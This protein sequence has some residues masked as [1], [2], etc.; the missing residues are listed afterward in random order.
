MLITIL[1]GLHCCKLTSFFC[2]YG[3][4]TDD[5]GHSTNH[6]KL[7]LLFCC[8]GANI[9]FDCS[10]HWT[11]PNHKH[12]NHINLC[13]LMN[14]WTCVS[15][16]QIM[17]A[18]RQPTTTNQTTKTSL[19]VRIDRRISHFA[20]VLWHKHNNEITICSDDCQ[21]IDK[22]WCLQHIFHWTLKCNTNPAILGAFHRSED[23]PTKWG[24]AQRSDPLPNRTVDADCTSW[25]YGC[26]QMC[27][28]LASVSRSTDDA[29]K[30]FLLLCISVI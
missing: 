9:L 6:R 12:C 7:A 13:L 19:H 28:S 11:P 25:R 26:C 16:L 8:R 18:V 29:Y 1:P 17:C 2:D 22:S 3:L 14:C 27:A 30:S 20:F 5:T 15:S 10:P 21:S 23:I 24:C 4:E